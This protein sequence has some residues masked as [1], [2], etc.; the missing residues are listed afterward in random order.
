MLICSVLSQALH[1]CQ[2]FESLD[3]SGKRI[4]ELGAGTGLVGIVAARLGKILIYACA[5]VCLEVFLKC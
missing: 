5:I 1:L 3:L 4:I 2:F